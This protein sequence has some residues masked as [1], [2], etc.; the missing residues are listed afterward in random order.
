[1]FEPTIPRDSLLLFTQCLA[2]LTLRLCSAPKQKVGGSSLNLFI[3]MDQIRCPYRRTSIHT[4]PDLDFIT[5]RVSSNS[6]TPAIPLAQLCSRPRLRRPSRFPWDEGRR[7]LLRAELDALVRPSLRDSPATSFATS[8]IPAEVMGADYPS[9]TFRVLKDNE[10]LKALQASTAPGAL[11]STPG[12]AW[13]AANCPARSH[14][15]FRR[16]VLR[17]P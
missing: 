6:P 8:S 16:R 7:A 9:E 5:F 17:D 13:S 2:S 4:R 1:M 11:F 15:S 10:E 3:V 14:T 12:I